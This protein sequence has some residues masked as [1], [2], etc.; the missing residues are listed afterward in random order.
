MIYGFLLIFRN[1]TTVISILRHPFFKS[2]TSLSKR[3][4]ILEEYHI[5]QMGV[6]NNSSSGNGMFIAIVKKHGHK[7]ADLSL[8]EIFSVYFFFWHSGGAVYT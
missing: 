4:K 3:G 1:K 2:K 5:S 7:S 8:G 6:E